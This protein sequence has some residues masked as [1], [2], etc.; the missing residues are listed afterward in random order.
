MPNMWT[1]M[2]TIQL[3]INVRKVPEDGEI[4]MLSNYRPDYWKNQPKLVTKIIT[5]QD[6]EDADG[7]MQVMF[8]S[9]NEIYI[10]TRCHNYGSAC[11]NFEFDYSK[12]ELEKVEPDFPEWSMTVSYTH[13]TLPT[14][15]IV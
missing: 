6:V 7:D 15:R 4:L 1:K 14:K 9:T 3:S 12:V 10:I 2:N 11:G 13:L 8:K 5:A